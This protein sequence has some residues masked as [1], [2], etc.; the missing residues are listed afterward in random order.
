MGYYDESVVITGKRK[1]AAEK[2]VW[3]K[4]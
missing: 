3:I 4:E 1:P 2:T